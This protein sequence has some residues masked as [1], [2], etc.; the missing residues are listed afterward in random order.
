MT[1]IASKYPGRPCCTLNRPMASLP[2]LTPLPS[3][4]RNHVFTLVSW[5]CARVLFSIA[6]QSLSL[7]CHLSP[8]LHRIYGI[9]CHRLLS[10]CRCP[11][12]LGKEFHGIPRNCSRRNGCRHLGVNSVTVIPLKLPESLGN[13]G[14]ARKSSQIPRKFH[15][16]N[17]GEFLILLE[18][19]ESSIFRGFPRLAVTFFFSP[20]NS[21]RHLKS[22]FLLAIF[23][24]LKV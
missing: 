11:P 21:F 18:N 2:H 7:Y 23:P 24:G 17:N 10:L 8:H 5:C 16:N 19:S 4:Q 14:I 13:F 15:K 22:Q 12:G 9:Q 6:S 3:Q 20:R 1:H